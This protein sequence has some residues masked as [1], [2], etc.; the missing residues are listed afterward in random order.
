MVSPKRFPLF[1]ALWLLL[2]YGLFLPQWGFYW[3]DWTPLLVTHLPHPD[4]KDSIAAFW[5]NR[6]GSG[7]LFY[8][9]FRVLPPVPWVW[10]VWGLVLRWF[11]ALMAWLLWRRVWPGREAPAQLA[12]LLFTVYPAF[13][14]QP[15]AVAYSP[16]WLSIGLALFSLW[17]MLR[18]L[19]DPRPLRW[20][21]PS[22]LGLAAS[23]LLIEY[24]L[25][26]EAFRWLLLA[27]HLRH[28]RLP[29]RRWL[30][31]FAPYLLLFLAGV[32]YTQ[33]S[34]ATDIHLPRATPLH[35]LT[36]GAR[37][38]SSSLYAFVGAWVHYWSQPDWW[39]H[40]NPTHWKTTVLPGLAL[41]LAAAV[42]VYTLLRRKP[43]PGTLHLE[44]RDLLYVLVV[45]FAV[46]LPFWAVNRYVYGLYSDRYLMPALFALPVFWIWLARFLRE[47]PPQW[48]FLA[49]LTGLAV[50][51]QAQHGWTFIRSWKD[52]RNF[53]TQLH[54][55]FPDL[56]PGTA[57]IGQGALTVYI[58]KY[59]VAES[60]NV[61]YHERIPADDRLGFWF[62]GDDDYALLDKAWREGQS[63]VRVRHK[64]WTFQGSWER[65]VMIAHNH[66]G[67]PG[68]L[69]VLGPWDATNPWLPEA[70]RLWVKRLA[71]MSVG[72]ERGT[73]P[74][75]T[76]AAPPSFLVETPAEPTWCFYYQKANRARAAGQW[77]AAWQWWQEA[78]ARGL[79]P[80]HAHEYGLFIEAAMHTH[81]WE[82]ALELTWR[83]WEQARDAGFPRQ[84]RIYLCRGVWNREDI[85]EPGYREVRQRVRQ[86]LCSG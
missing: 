83:Y 84:A 42:L 53:Y 48:F 62:F 24:A 69:W 34:R 78:Q 40:P 16:H 85:A 81:R 31:W 75:G 38:A 55:R 80:G 21:A 71:G 19:E 15:I 82:E 29:R 43:T 63:E 32:G 39:W 74:E 77:E 25:P 50:F 47:G 37:I 72:M 7:V 23:F 60:I 36:T 3:D 57:F 86:R 66:R 11:T 26:L 33:V 20:L 17:S 54:W 5:G 14:Q 76:E 1:L 8:L 65:M 35:M 18:A 79:R 51:L 58:D 70:M 9:L 49:A 4:L 27:I 52:Q 28:R 2:V 10:Q 44:H 30:A 67:M 56:P 68:C 13:R 59:V 64:Q 45:F 46:S 6:P 41:A 12:A 61:L 73:I 22:W